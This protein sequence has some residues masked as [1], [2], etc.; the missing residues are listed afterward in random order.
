MDEGG[1]VMRKYLL[2]AA[3]GVLAASSAQGASAQSSP[4]GRSEQ[5]TGVE[6][7]V[8]TAQRREQRAQD[9][10]I[11]ISVLNGDAL[12]K[13]GVTNINQL[14]DK[15]PNLEVEPAFG[16]G[17][18]QYR[19]RGVGFQDYA[20]N[21]SP[22]V[23][24]YVDEVAYPVP[25]M[26]QGMLFDI[27]R[28]EI[29]RGPQGTLYGRNTTGGAINFLTGNPTADFHSG[30]TAE[31][32]R[33]SHFVGEGYVSGPISDTLKGRISIGVDEG[34]GFQHN[35]VTG[36]SLGDADRVAGRA[37]FDWAATDKLDL[38]LNLHAGYDH[39]E[40]QGLYLFQDFHTASGAGPTV[41]A[42]TDHFATGWGLR[43]AF[44]AENGIDPSRKPGKHNSTAGADFY[45]DYDLGA[46]K[47]SSI[48]AYEHMNRNEVGDWDATQFAESDVFWKGDEGVFS[49]ELRLAS[50]GAGRL[51]WVGGLYYSHQTQDEVYASDFTNVFGIGAHVSYSQKVESISGFGQ[52][53]YE[54][55]DQLKL[56]GGLRYEH[57]TRDLNGFAS[58]FGGAT[59]LV[60]TNESTSMS[61]LT[62]K[63]ELDFKPVSRVLLY[64]SASKGVKSGGFTAYNSADQSGIEPFKPETLYAYEAGFKTNLTPEL[65]LNGALYYYDYRNEQV[66]SVVC[67]ANGPVGKFANAPKSQIH[68]AELEAVWQPVEGLRISQSGSYKKGEFKEFEDVDVSIC[69]A[70]HETVFVNRAGQP[71]KFPKWSYGGD[72]SYD[73]LMGTYRV[74]A[75]TDYSWHDR[76]PS[77]LGTTYDLDEYWL[78][79][80][81]LTVGPDEGPWSASVWVRNIFDKDYDLTRNFFVNANVAQPGLPRTYGVRLNYR[82]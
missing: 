68:G 31:Y 1:L 78:V 28:V 15:T 5:A 69:Q 49:Q 2:G 29:L 40:S 81:S 54:L 33:F 42:D 51:H 6:E 65:Q 13:E 64:L 38:R 9:V 25:V 55:T 82:F 30:F 57:E 45:V 24:V 16:G 11:A 27:D 34:G 43:P 73:W 47:L 58:E 32:G 79:N 56:I 62:G 77:W 75:Q 20:A 10:G 14:Q 52:A 17:Q 53:E 67:T 76:Y 48:T 23:G 4:R 70:T 59:G 44:A 66:L 46:A 18:P 60:P 61:P 74:T 21:N 37:K 71:I 50:N 41:P 26:T 39:S 19:I 22:T 80:A 12:A 36:E 35:R 63:A 72:I 3:L 8:V 7:V